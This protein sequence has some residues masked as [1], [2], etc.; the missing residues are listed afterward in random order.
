VLPDVE[1]GFVRYTEK[2]LTAA[3]SGQLVFDPEQRH[4]LHS[5]ANTLAETIIPTTLQRGEGVIFD[6]RAWAHGRLALGAGQES[7]PHAQRR[8]LLQC[9]VY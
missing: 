9:Y 8:L 5:L 6:Q 1:D 7:I 3:D 4:A 2:M